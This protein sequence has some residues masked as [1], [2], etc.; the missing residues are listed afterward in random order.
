MIKFIYNGGIED[1]DREKVVTAVIGKCKKKFSLPDSIEVEFRKLEPAVYAE[2]LIEFR[3]KNRIRLNSSLN[4]VDVIK[5]LIHE[6]L[7]LNQTHTNKLYGRR[8]G[9]YVWLGKAYKVNEDINYNQYKNLPWEKDVSD[10]ET[11]ILDEILEEFKKERG[12]Q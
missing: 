8:D 7:H 1:K 2:T 4:Y 9:A 10:K 3:F 11:N 6:L 12:E 5:P